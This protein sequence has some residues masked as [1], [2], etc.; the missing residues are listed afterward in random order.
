VQTIGATA[1]PQ[2]AS[3]PARASLRILD[4]APL[5][6][7][8]S[9][10]LCGDACFAFKA[11]VRHAK[12]RALEGTPRAAFLQWSVCWLLIDVGLLLPL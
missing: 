8:W 7:R 12:K 1:F 3:I 6:G 11:A 10:R 5:T 4:V 9:A 2:K